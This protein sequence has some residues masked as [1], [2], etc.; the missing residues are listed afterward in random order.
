MQCPVFSERNLSVQQMS[1]R[2]GWLYDP[3]KKINTISDNACGIAVFNCNFS[4]D[5]KEQLLSYRNNILERKVKAKEETMFN[6]LTVCTWIV[7]STF[8]IQMI[9][10]LF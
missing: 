6:F 9:W 10:L 2:I 1:A 3:K 7:Y 4:D 5:E 8:D